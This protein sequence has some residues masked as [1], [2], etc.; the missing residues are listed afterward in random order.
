V[1]SFGAQGNGTSNDAPAFQAAINAVSQRGGGTVVVPVPKA[2]YRI[3]TSI[4]LK[5]DV[6]IVG[7]GSEQPLL[8]GGIPSTYMFDAPF[9]SAVH[10]IKLADLAIDLGH[11]NKASGVNMQN[12]SNISIN[13][14]DVTNVTGGWAINVGVGSPH[15]NTATTYNQNITVSNCTFDTIDSKFTQLL[16]FNAQNVII[17]GNHFTNVAYNPSGGSLGL[18]QNDHNFLISQNTF[19][20]NLGNDAMFY[21]IGDS[22]LRIVDNNF[23][24][25]SSFPAQGNDGIKGANESDHGLFGQTTAQSLT[26]TG[27]KFSDFQI[28]LALQSVDGATVSQ[29]QFTNNK[30]AILY[31]R[32]F[33]GRGSVVSG[34]RQGPLSSNLSVSN[35]QLIGN[36]TDQSNSPKG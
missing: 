8:T 3:T 7:S 27:N 24:G 21:A 25:S 34:S 12:V 16:V 28:A 29:N 35:N 19:G 10:D 36:V 5:S 9:A 22:G 2:S 11:L 15:F 6:N 30:I 13:D 1:T 33:E 23:V 14:L 4:R 26:I 32:A 20:P 31:H 18:Y 17:T